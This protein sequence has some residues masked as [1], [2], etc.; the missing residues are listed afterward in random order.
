MKKIYSSVL[1]IV[2]LV[3][4]T[5]ILNGQ[6]FNGGVF[7]TVPGGGNYSNVAT[8]LGPA[9]PLSCTNCK[10]VL[11]GN[12]TID[13]PGIIL[14]SN[15]L[16][17]IT[18][19]SILTI[20]ER[21]VI[22]DSTE[23]LVGNGGP[24]S[25]SLVMNAEGDV[26]SKSFIRLTN[27]N[28][29]LDATSGAMSGS[30]SSFTAFFGSGFFYIIGPNKFNVLISTSGYGDTTNMGAKFFATYNFNCNATNPP[31]VCTT[32][33]VFGPAISDTSATD[34]LWEFMAASLLPVVLNQFAAVL[35]YNQLVEIS[36]ATS[37]E[38]NSNYFSIQ[39]SSDA[40]NFNE[41]GKTK[42]KGFSSINTDYSFTDPESLNGT[43]YYRLEMVDKD[44][45]FEYSKVISISSDTKTT[46]VVVFNN[47]FTDQVRLLVNTG[48][49]DN[50]RFTMTDLLGRVCLQQ[51]HTTQKG[52]NFIDLQSSNA[53]SAGIYF[54][55]IKSNT[56]NRT[57]KLIKQ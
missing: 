17:V 5:Q 30:D 14:D 26:F 32:G 7:I 20:N 29:F 13:I 55:N 44:G 21:I 23:I 31:P 42:A 27:N 50:L 35:T 15:S 28:T 57:I 36:W 22:K 47:P 2:V 40:V 51:Y 46:S 19:G 18:T 54:L 37:Q 24:G 10:I 39:R 33:E 3:F 53:I 41:I 11:N 45:K 34:Q 49:P 12:V 9:P 43:S 52:S 48:I 38:V 8:W 6:T 16:V 56:I 25:A 4:C 1:T